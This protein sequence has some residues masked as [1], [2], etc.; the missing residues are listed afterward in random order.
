L[1]TSCIILAG[2]KGARFGSNKV[3]E[4][5]G[6]KN[7]LQQVIS[8]ISSL[9]SDIIVVTA[10]E[11]NISELIEHPN[12]RVVTDAFPAKGPL[13]GIY[14]G[15]SI[16][17]SN[18]ALAVA[19][20]MPFLNLDLLR[21]M[22]QLSDNWDA[23]VPRLGEMVEPLHAVYSKN[24]LITIEEMINQDK[25]SVYQ[26]FNLIKVRYVE[27][28]EVDRFDPGHLSIFNINT[29]ADLEKARKMAERDYA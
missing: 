17:N 13:G 28:E 6:N 2:G 12:L 21:Y 23:V 16:S 3:L 5:V 9:C 27:A 20:D 18:H 4:T 25:L 15:L 7:L 14:T 19:C 24:C 11:P 29:R 10:E 8:R 22:V 1:D 26:L